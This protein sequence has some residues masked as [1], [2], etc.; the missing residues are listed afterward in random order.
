MFQIQIYNRGFFTEMV[1]MHDGIA[2]SAKD[3]TII[4]LYFYYYL[5]YYLE[6]FLLLMVPKNVVYIGGSLGF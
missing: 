2:C 5:T 4:V 3:N 1:T 6:K